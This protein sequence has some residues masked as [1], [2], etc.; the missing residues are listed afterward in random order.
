M[1]SEAHHIRGYL[2][3]WSTVILAIKSVPAINTAT[4]VLHVRRGLDM[5]ARLVNYNKSI[6][7]ENKI[8]DG[9]PRPYYRR[10]DI[11]RK[12]GMIRLAAQRG[13]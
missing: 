7:C 3:R 8:C 13:I 4:L 9:L 11:D 10:D 12:V 6:V 1:V 2:H 5:N